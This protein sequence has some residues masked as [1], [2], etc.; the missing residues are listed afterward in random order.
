[1]DGVGDCDRCGLGCLWFGF[2]RGFFGWLGIVMYRDIV[3]INYI[4]E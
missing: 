2:L 3:F 4:S 1:M